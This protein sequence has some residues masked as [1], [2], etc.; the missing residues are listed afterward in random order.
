MNRYYKNKHR[1]NFTQTSALLDDLVLKNISRKG[2]GDPG[3]LFQW[4][5]IVGTEMGLVTRPLKLI[6]SKDSQCTILKVQVNNSSAPQISLSLE[7]M[8]LKINQFFGYEAVSKI[9]MQ[10][11]GPYDFKELKLNLKSLT[12]L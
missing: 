9:L 12:K 7:K 2:F 3:L 4:Q 11:K 6:F 10:Q 5:D 1:G 8:K